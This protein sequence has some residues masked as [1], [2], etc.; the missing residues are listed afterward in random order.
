MLTISI[1]AGV[2]ALGDVVEAISGGAVDERVQE[3]QLRA[4]KHTE[5]VSLDILL[6][7]DWPWETL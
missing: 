4:C 7:G 2:S 1:T 3:A 6:T 5:E